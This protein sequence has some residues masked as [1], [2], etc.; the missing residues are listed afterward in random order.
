MLFSRTKR[1]AQQTEKVEEHPVQFEL[2]R[3][4][5]KSTTHGTIPSFLSKRPYCNIFALLLKYL[6]RGRGQN[7]SRDSGLGRLFIASGVV[8]AAAGKTLFSG[9]TKMY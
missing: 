2:E 5:F 3:N 9:P 6:R 8:G 1:V 4:G 7:R